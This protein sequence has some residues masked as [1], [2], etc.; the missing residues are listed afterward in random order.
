MD[1][2]LNKSDAYEVGCFVGAAGFVTSGALIHNSLDDELN[3]LDAFPKGKNMR[4]SLF[5]QEFT[6]GGFQHLR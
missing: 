6:S 4:K 5:L 1:A 2:V 3:M